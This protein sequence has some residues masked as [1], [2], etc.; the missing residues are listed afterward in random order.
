MAEKDPDLSSKNVSVSQ[1]EVGHDLMSL[2]DPETLDW[3]VFLNNKCIK[4]II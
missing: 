2:S 1:R 4:L 3:G